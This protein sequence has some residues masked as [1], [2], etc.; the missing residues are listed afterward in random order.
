M[1]A[2]LAC[3]RNDHDWRLVLSAAGVCMIGCLA[4]MLLLSRAQECAG[5]Q[6]RSWLAAAA[7]A[8]GVG[9]WSTHF[10]AILAYRGGFPISYGLSLTLLSVVFAIAG[11]AGAI[12]V[13][14]LGNG[15]PSQAM[16]GLLMAL[17][18]ALMHFTGMRAIEAPAN[19]SYDFLGVA[20]AF[21]I[22]ALFCILAFV[23]FHKVSGWR[24]IISASL[25]LV[26]A[27]CILHF[28]AMSSV[29]L[30][31][32]PERQV[33]AT[34][35]DR[36]ILAGIIIVS[37]TVLILLALGAVFVER[38]LTDLRGLANASLE[39]L[40]IVRDGHIIDANERFLAISGCSLPQ[41]VGKAPSAFLSADC[42]ARVEGDVLVET[43]LTTREGS[44]ISVEIATRKI[45]YRGHE[46]RVFVLRDLTERREAQEMIEHLALHDM[47]TD[48]P[49]RTLFARRIGQAL[50][51]AT[52]RN[53]AVAVFYLDLDRFKAVNDIFGHAEGDRILKKVAQILHYAADDRS[54]TVARLGGDEFAI[55]QCGK[56][57]P[58]GARRLSEEI[59]KRFAAE[60]DVSRDPTAVG[61]SMGIA[62]YPLDG[63][64]PEQLCANADT[65]LYRAKHDGRGSACFFDSDMD[66]TIRSRRQLEAD[67]RQAIF[68]NQFHLSY[69][70]ILDARSGNTSGYEALL[71]WSHPT[72]G[73]IEPEVF[74]PIAE[75]GGS[76]I[77]IGEWVLE[78]ACTEAAR[79]RQDMSIAV[80][81]S[82]VQFLLPTL[83]DQVERILA[84]TGLDPAR[85]EL[86]ITESALIRDRGAV[87]SILWRLHKLGVRVVMDDFGTGYSSLSNLRAFPFDKIK[88]DRSFTGALEHDPAARSIVRAIIGLGHSL[89]MSVVTEGVETETQR[90]IV[91]E[92]GSAQIQGFLLGKPDIEPSIRFPARSRRRGLQGGSRRTVA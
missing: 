55:I 82:P 15:L 74:I 52:V 90:R 31:P 92:E 34:A 37:S 8:C 40:L 88:I 68:R 5:W 38:H 83:Y 39:G 23:T 75:E 73:M 19:F 27:I 45:T 89:D 1:F 35:I 21:V 67:L 71:R 80:N 7:V 4:T 77:K 79:W 47:L 3:I 81:V 9:I 61:V 43:L 2:V 65:A 64:T 50:Q 12:A 26:L 36:G 28:T 20:A 14:S 60:M 16:G 22:G 54:D 44:Q 78:Q 59:L 13:G 62:L 66:Q 84:K 30:V 18:V 53:E 33:A 46:C 24:G 49:N 25:L 51:A 63:S 85:L 76:I 56:D 70:P 11:A 17:G 6:R 57:Q 72:C 69:Q 58:G 91:V 29:T 48:L 87:L 10:I 41:V 86:E 32:D 42:I